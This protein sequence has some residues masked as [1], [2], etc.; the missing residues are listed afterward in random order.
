MRLH[1]PVL[2]AVLAAAVVGVPALPASAALSEPPIVLNGSG[3]TP[4]P[5]K[6]MAMILDTTWGP[7]YIA[8]QQKSNLTVT[9][10]GTDTITFRD[11]GTRSWKDGAAYMPSHC[12]KQHVKK[13]VKATCSILPQ[14][15]DG[16]FV[17]VWPRLGNDRVDGSTLPSWVRF[18]VL[19]D[20]GD[21]VVWGGA[22]DDFVNGA[23]GVDTVHG[24]D[25]DDWI[26][27]GLG[28]D[29][30]YGDGGD[31]ELVGVDGA[32]EVHGGVGRDRVGGGPG[33]D[34]LFG[35]AGDDALI[36]ASG[37]DTAHY[38]ADDVKLY[39][40]ETRIQDPLLP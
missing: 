30:I 18:W 4:I 19:A 38:D 28:D 16:M 26:R 3:P 10:S 8:G 6:N 24:G 25:G 23:K 39:Q 32:D 9:V 33:A 1:A 13:G 40:C 15:Q 2:A 27:T 5:L 14:F 22:G 12:T 36:C 35:D 11:K 29:V 37:K 17:Q 31:D 20:E 34:R 7:R 21:D